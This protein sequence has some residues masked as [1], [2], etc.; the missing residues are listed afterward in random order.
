MY[1]V[2]GI[3]GLGGELWLAKGSGA[4][5]YHGEHGPKT[6][7]TPG[8]YGHCHVRR[9]IGTG[10]NSCSGVG[11]YIDPEG[12]SNRIPGTNRTGNQCGEPTR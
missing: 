7:G 9:E 10:V 5:S 4:L 6:Q 8:V 11:V 2:C 1:P 3:R 12:D